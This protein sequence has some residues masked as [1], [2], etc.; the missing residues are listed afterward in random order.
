M[1]PFIII[2]V[3]GVHTTEGKVTQFFVSK[4]KASCCSA[5]WGRADCGIPECSAPLLE[6]VHGI[7]EVRAVR[8]LRATCNLQ[9]FD[10]VVDIML[11]DAGPNSTNIDKCE[12][13]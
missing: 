3:I 8:G 5:N 9:T 1:Q 10:E 7:V 12:P 2:A 11:L 13:L 6:G 4:V